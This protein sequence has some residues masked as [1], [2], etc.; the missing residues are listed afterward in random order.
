MAKFHLCGFCTK[1]LVDI[2]TFSG[3]CRV[4]AISKIKFL[5]TIVNIFTCQPLTHAQKLHPRC[6]MDARTASESSEICNGKVIFVTEY[7]VEFTKHINCY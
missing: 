2:V 5:V 3:R 6:G 1:M 4:P 7:K